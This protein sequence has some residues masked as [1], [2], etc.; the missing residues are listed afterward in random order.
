MQSRFEKGLKILTAQTGCKIHISEALCLIEHRIKS[1]RVFE[2]KKST[3]IK[4]VTTCGNMMI[5]LG[6]NRC[7]NYS[8]KRTSGGT[9]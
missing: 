3:S 4:T 6:H 5:I 8:E 1:Y 9:S 2:L 7:I